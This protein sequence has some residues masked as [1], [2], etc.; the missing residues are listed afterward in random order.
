ML[1]FSLP[2]HHTLVTSS[3]PT[4]GLSSPGELTQLLSLR[5]SPLSGAPQL[6]Q[7]LPLVLEA[8]IMT[9]SIYIIPDIG[10]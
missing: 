5:R 1:N 7:N 2:G 10:M 9:Y 8:G 4:E 3:L 6:F